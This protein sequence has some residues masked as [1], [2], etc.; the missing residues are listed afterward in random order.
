MLGGL[1]GDTATATEQSRAE[2]DEAC[3]TTVV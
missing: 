3:I 2:G 1:Y